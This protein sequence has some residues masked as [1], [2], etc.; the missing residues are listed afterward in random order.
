MRVVNYLELS[1]F[2]AR[3]QSDQI[4]RAVAIVLAFGRD[5]FDSLEQAVMEVR[6]EGWAVDDV[7]VF[8]T[9][10]AYREV[11][12]SD[13]LRHAYDRARSEGIDWYVEGRPVIE[14]SRVAG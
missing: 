5:L 13:R 12:G 8:K 1:I 6:K 4:E 10:V 7:P 11:S 14:A 2:R 9:D 3:E